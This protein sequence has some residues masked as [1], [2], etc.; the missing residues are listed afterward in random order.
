MAFWKSSHWATSPA[1]TLHLFFI[2]KG[3]KNVYE[4][5]KR[6]LS[7]LRALT[8]FAEGSGL[9]PRIYLA[10][11]NIGSSS[12]RRPNTLFGPPGIRHP[13]LKHTYIQVNPQTQKIKLVTFLKSPSCNRNG[14]ACLRCQQRPVDLCEFQGSQDSTARPCLKTEVLVFKNKNEKDLYAIKFLRSW[15]SWIKDFLNMIFRI[16]ALLP[17]CIQPLEMH[18]LF[19]Y[20]CL[21]GRN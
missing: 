3:Y 13:C 1:P 12:S 6:L 4:N 5:W 16:W 18:Y 9:V 2:E 11:H 7:G 19:L 20:I 8:T 15:N 14:S 21:V 17:S 10:S